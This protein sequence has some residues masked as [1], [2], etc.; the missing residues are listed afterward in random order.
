MP[1][2]SSNGSDAGFHEVT[3]KLSTDELMKKLKVRI[4][5]M[6]MYPYDVRNA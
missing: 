6:Y 5:F 4:R 1:W 2:P 3:S